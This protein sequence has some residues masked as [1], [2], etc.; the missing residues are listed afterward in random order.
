MEALRNKA[1][2]ASMMQN[3]SIARAS[4]I[5][6]IGAC[7]VLVALSFNMFLCLLTTRAGIHFSATIVAVIE[8]L[9]MAAGLVAIRHQVTPRAAQVIGILGAF[10][11]GMKL[12]NPALD[13][14]IISDIGIM[15]IFYELG[16]M[17]STQSANRLVWW[18]VWIVVAVGF[19]ELILPNIFVSLFDEWTYY[20][21]KGVIAKTVV[22]YSGTSFFI[23]GQRGGSMARTFFPSLFG[24][25]RVASIFLEPVSMGNFSVLVFA[26]CISTRADQP[27]KK[28]LLFALAALCFILGDSRFA[29]GCWIL[30]A[31]LRATPLYRSR[32][33]VF[34]LPVLAVL[35]L[36]LAGSIHEM[37]G[38]LPS[39]LHDDFAGRLLFSGRLLNYWSLQQWLALAPSQVY[40]SDT[41]YAYVINNLGLPMALFC[42]AIFAFHQPRTPEAVSMKAMISVYMAT[43]LCIGANMFTIK[44]AALL[45]FLY[46]AA[47]TAQAISLPRA[48]LRIGLPRGA[49]RI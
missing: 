26:W 34:C 49:V 32:F 20:V 14:K 16:M 11:I 2:P 27:M 38:V 35:G 29:S 44:T 43:S 1:A 25:H 36:V 24:P 17:S 9:I 33:V 39:I 13:L 12:L 41:G 31:V 37:P 7:L 19:F 28:A 3:S 21:D 15:Y 22:N 42:L 6:P 8:L 10:L 40:T 5:N 46:G 30:M 4:H 45:W 18:A 47:N 23:S 48:S